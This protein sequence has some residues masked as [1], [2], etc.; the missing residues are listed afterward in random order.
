MFHGS[1]AGTFARATST[2]VVILR[3]YLSPTPYRAYPP[4]NPPPLRRARP[5]LA[6]PR[7]VPTSPCLA[8]PDLTQPHPAQPHRAIPS[9][10]KSL[11]CLAAPRPTAPCMTRPCRTLPRL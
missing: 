5:D 3:L 8:L 7:R 9:L 11:P 2:A 4:P 1:A 10:A 6:M